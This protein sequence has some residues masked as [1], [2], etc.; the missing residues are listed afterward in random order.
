MKALSS[1]PHLTTFPALFICA[2]KVTTTR[3]SVFSIKTRKCAI[4]D[5]EKK[6]QQQ[7]TKKRKKKKGG[8]A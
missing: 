4:V 2:N 3:S 5:F 8:L 6:K 7:K 1:H